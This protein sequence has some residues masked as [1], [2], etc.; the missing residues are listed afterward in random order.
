MYSKEKGVSIYNYLCCLKRL[1]KDS[2]GIKK[3][4]VDPYE[5]LGLLGDLR[6]HELAM[7]F[8]DKVPRNN[9]WKKRISILLLVLRI[10][11]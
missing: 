1:N 11:A 2:L 5:E 8:N 10:R 3:Y 7:S 4:N 6:V 9:L